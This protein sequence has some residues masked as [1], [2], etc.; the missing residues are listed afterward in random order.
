PFVAE[1]LTTLVYQ[2]VCEPAPPA[3]RLNPTLGSKIEA[4]LQKGLSKTPAD[5][6]PGCAAFVDA[7][8]AACAATTGWRSLARGGSLNLPT[9]AET[10][11]QAAAPAPARIDPPP[12]A[13]SPAP[14]PRDLPPPRPREEAEPKSR[15]VPILIAL[16][17][18]CVI[19][20]AV[21]FVRQ[22]I[23]PKATP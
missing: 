16:V 10:R 22:P 18:G 3:H 8:E 14:A 6:F 13:S 19:G 9:M 7:L 17:A 4:V 20:V 2:I 11:A 12:P 15:A 5:R 21:Y 1:H 23:D